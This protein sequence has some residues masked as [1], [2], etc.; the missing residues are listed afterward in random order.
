M[1]TEIVLIGI[2]AFIGPALIS[3]FIENKEDII[4]IENS[5]WHGNRSPENFEPQHVP[6][7]FEPP[8]PPENFE[9]QHVPENFEPPPMPKEFKPK[10]V[11]EELFEPPPMPK[12]FKP[13]SVPEEL[14]EPPP[15]PEE[16]EPPLP[17]PLYESFFEKAKEDSRVQEIIDGRGYKVMGMQH[18]DGIDNVILM[19]EIEGKNYEVVFNLQTETVESVSWV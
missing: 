17:P 10:S 4:E 13:K 6:E 12:E 16:F 19:V 14:F 11:P 8:L 5:G 9:P 18:V 15:M 1:K 3:G 2:L 7:E